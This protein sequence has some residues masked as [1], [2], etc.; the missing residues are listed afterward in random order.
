[1]GGSPLKKPKGRSRTM[2]KTLGACPL[3]GV[4]VPSEQDAGCPVIEAFGF[5]MTESK[6]ASGG[7]PQRSPRVAASTASSPTSDAQ[8]T[9]PPLSASIVA[10]RPPIAVANPLAPAS[11]DTRC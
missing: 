11:C 8:P 10:G 7:I 3:C 6:R 9:A 2:D 4:N 5:V 1:M